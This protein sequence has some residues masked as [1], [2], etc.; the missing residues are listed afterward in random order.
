MHES[1][2]TAAPASAALIALTQR[3]ARTIATT[4]L[5]AAVQRLAAARRDA[6]T[7]A[8]AVRSSRLSWENDHAGLLLSERQAQAA[9]ERA[10]AE[11]RALAEAH[12]DATGEKRPAPG[13]EIKIVT[14]VEISD[15]VAALTYAK[16][17]DLCLLLDEKT[18]KLLA[19]SQDVPG[20]TRADVPQAS[21]SRNLDAAL[22]AGGAT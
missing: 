19:R 15:P 18:Y 6:V 20:T 8:A 5:V 7:V 9:E 2:T 3:G 10:E 11:L 1:E 4:H 14:R 17:I 16:K 13:V 22:A 21:V 12:Y